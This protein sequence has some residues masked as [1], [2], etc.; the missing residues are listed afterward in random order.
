[1]SFM[2]LKQSMQNFYVSNA[3]LYHSASIFNS[4]WLEGGD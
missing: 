2:L 3:A 4:D 1:M